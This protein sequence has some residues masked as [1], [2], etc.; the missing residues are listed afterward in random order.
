MAKLIKKI[1]STIVGIQGLLFSISIQVSGQTSDV[2]ALSPEEQ[3]AIHGMTHQLNIMTNAMT[4]SQ[5]EK[6]GNSLLD[7]NVRADAK[8]PNQFKSNIKMELN[9]VQFDT[10][11]LFATE[12]KWGQ[13]RV[14]FQANT[15]DKN[16]KWTENCTVKFYIG[17]DKRLPDGKMLLLKSSCTCITLPTNSE[18]AVSFFI[19]GDIRHKYGLAC[20]PDYCAVHFSVDG[21]SQ[22]IITVNK[23][24]KNAYDAR[25]SNTHK[26]IKQRSHI[27]IRIMRNIDQLPRHV[28][29]DVADHPALLLD[30]DV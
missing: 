21:I 30:I 19:P 8:D 28:D 23:E 2:A 20:V 12:K 26:D 17:F 22:P 5:A 10:Q 27:E 25:S 29:I 24:G 4:Q 3:S 16:I 1:L 15:E 7:A 18:Q 6:V 11:R 9:K 13:I 14:F